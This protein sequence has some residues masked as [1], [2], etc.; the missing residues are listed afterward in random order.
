MCN[1]SSFRENCVTHAR[2]HVRTHMVQI[3]SYNNNNKNTDKTFSQIAIHLAFY[4]YLERQ[5]E[6]CF[7]REKEITFLIQN[8][9][10]PMSINDIS[11]ESKILS[12]SLY[13]SPFQR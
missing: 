1:C 5:L 7:P 13:L 9:S 8:Q 3:K 11:W 4:F 10:V 12:K 2:T 6:Y